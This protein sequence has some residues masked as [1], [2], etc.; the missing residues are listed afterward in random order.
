MNGLDNIAPDIFKFE[1][2]NNKLNIVPPPIECPITNKG[3]SFL[4]FD[5]TEKKSS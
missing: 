4:T 3:K 1:F 5:K 2:F